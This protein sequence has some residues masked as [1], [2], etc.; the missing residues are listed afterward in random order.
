MIQLAILPGPKS[1]KDLD[2]FLRPIVEEFKDLSNYGLVVRRNGNEICQAKVNLVIAKGDIPA[3]ASLAHHSGH[4]SLN[5]C[6]LCRIIT[7]RNNSRTCYLDVD[8]P[9]R[10]KTDFTNANSAFASAV[11]I[12]FEKKSERI[13]P[14][15]KHVHLQIEK[16]YLCRTPLCFSP[17]VHWT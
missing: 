15:Y 13:L 11:S 16:W 1:P 17:N 5:G 2:S 14:S 9:M 7:Q 10:D 4:M 6:R 12:I 3:A 8:A